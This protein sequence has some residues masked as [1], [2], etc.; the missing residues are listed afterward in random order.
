M[1]IK[2][3]KGEI[4]AHL[5]QTCGI[6][7]DIPDGVGCGGTTTTGNVARRLKNN[8]SKNSRDHLIECG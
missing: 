6:Q 7:L 5:K 1:L 8:D 3:A 4:Q 2:T